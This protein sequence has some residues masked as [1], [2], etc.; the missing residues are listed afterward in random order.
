MEE[1]KVM[2]GMEEQVWVVKLA[3]AT[4]VAWSNESKL[5]PSSPIKNSLLGNPSNNSIKN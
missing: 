5:I 2:S 3:V 1:H 4:A